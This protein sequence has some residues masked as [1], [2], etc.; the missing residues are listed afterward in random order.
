MRRQR[1]TI[2]L[3]DRTDL[4]GHQP[5]APWSAAEDRMINSKRQLEA[6]SKGVHSGDSVTGDRSSIDGIDGMNSIV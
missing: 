3:E 1:W 2:P 4:A 6:M 5:A